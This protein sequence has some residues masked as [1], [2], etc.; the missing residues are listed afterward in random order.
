MAERERLLTLEQVA[1]RLQIKMAFLRKMVFQRRLPVTRVG[2]L[3][4]VREREL[5]RWIESRTTP[6]REQ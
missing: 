6:A 3:V 4:R 1:E 5:E 2:R